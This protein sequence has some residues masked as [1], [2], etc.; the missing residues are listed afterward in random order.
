MNATF[1][2]I[3]DFALAIAALLILFA[4]GPAAAQIGACNPPEG[5]IGLSRDKTE[6]IRG[7]DATENKCTGMMLGEGGVWLHC[8]PPEPEEQGCLPEQRHRQWGGPFGDMCNSI[9]PG[10]PLDP[11]KHILQKAPHG[12]QQELQD[13]FGNTIGRA[14]YRCVRGTWSEEPV[15]S[16]CAYKVDPNAPPPPR[17]VLKPRQGDA[18]VGPV[19][20]RR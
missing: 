20:I 14:T 16:G 10:T 15:L 6:Q 12:G 19:Q 5:T 9:P 8:Q 11:A 2:R 4:V 17:V 7:S 18:K 3:I 1:S 13:D